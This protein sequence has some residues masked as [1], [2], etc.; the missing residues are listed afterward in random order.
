M[1]CERKRFPSPPWPENASEIVEGEQYEKTD[2]L[3]GE[4]RTVT[5]LKV[6]ES[7]PGTVTHYEGVI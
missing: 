2:P 7:G 3:T 5:V 4:T 1:T 6:D